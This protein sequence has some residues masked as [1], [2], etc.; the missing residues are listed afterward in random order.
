MTKIY[1]LK[2]GATFFLT[3]RKTT[4]WRLQ[5][6]EGSTAIITAV[7]SQITWKKPKNTVCYLPTEG[8]LSE[9]PGDGF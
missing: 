5:K 8:Q 7:E 3:K 6:I 4:M 9:Y 2:D 1:Q